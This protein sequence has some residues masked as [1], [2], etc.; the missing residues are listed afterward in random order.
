MCLQM[1]PKLSVLVVGDLPASCLTR[2]ICD[3]EPS[4]T[5]SVASVRGT[6]SV[7]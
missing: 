4:V 1:S 3:S 2:A 7:L 6:A 5:E